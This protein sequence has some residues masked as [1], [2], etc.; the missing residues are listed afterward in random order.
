MATLRRLTVAGKK[1]QNALL[2]PEVRK[3]VTED[4]VGYGM[5]G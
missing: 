4:I 3:G 5:L 1:T 2:G